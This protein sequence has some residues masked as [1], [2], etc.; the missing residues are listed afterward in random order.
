[1]KNKVK[2]EKQQEEIKEIFSNMFKDTTDS[3]RSDFGNL[4]VLKG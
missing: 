1:M 2:S 3:S 4:P